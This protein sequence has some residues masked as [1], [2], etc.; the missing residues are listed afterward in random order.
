M[1]ST[2]F[3]KV[4]LLAITFTICGASAAFASNDIYDCDDRAGAIIEHVY[5]SARAVRDGYTMGD[6][7]IPV[8]DGFGGKTVVCRVWPAHPQYTLAAVPL[9]RS[10]HDGRSDGDIELFVLDTGNLAIEARQ[11]LPGWASADGLRIA[12]IGI[13]TANYRLAPNQ[14]AF[15]L[16]IRRDNNS[17]VN[18]LTVQSLSLFE[19]VNHDIR[20]RLDH[21]ETVRG[22]AYMGYGGCG[23]QS[24]SKETELSMLKPSH[25]G[26]YDIDV[27]VS[28]SR[29]WQIKS[30]DQCSDRSSH[31]V[32]HHALEFDG[33]Q[34]RLPAVLKMVH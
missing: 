20:T 12:H 1:Q 17:S 30:G 3:F 4:S 5:P 15:A 34:Y 9:I 18:P 13:D 27:A 32:S 2:P 11:M 8:T 23:D 14:L 7:N 26:Y 28:E 24:K 19:V 31:S 16:R 6:V 25:H 21:L 10:D 22:Q 29:A 33:D